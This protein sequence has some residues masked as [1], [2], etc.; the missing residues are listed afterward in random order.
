MSLGLEVLGTNVRAGRLEIDVIARAGEVI[1]IVEVRTRGAG[2]W[3]KALD[4]IGWKKRRR[5][6]H[7]GER[8]WRTRFSKQPGVE[9]MRFDCA[10]VTFDA[11][12][13]AT[14]E[15]VTAAF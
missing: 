13:S 7:A 9:R 2:A 11:D 1:A 14:V 5:I 8:L 10:S 6:R 12:D 4:S 15:Y 3:E